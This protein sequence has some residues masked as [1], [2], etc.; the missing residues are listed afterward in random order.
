MYFL[1]LFSYLLT[2]TLARTGGILVTQLHRHLDILWFL[3]QQWRWYNQKV[4][5]RVAVGAEI[6]GGYRCCSDSQSQPPPPPTQ[7]PCYYTAVRRGRHA[8]GESS[9]MQSHGGARG[10]AAGETAADTILHS[11]LIFHTAGV[12]GAAVCEQCVSAMWAQCLSSVCEWCRI[13][14]REPTGLTKQKATVALIVFTYFR[15]ISASDGK[16]F[17]WCACGGCWE[18]GGV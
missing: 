10:V 3:W 5:V 14:T 15:K 2:P 16:S 8:V 7:P 11:L 17:W 9:A 12:E 1:I 4:G 18:G 6:R 13:E